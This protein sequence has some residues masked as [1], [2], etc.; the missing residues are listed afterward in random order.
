MTVRAQRWHVP[1]SGRD[2]EEEH[3]A[4]TP[5][6]LFFDLCFVVAVAQASVALHHEVAEGHL[7]EG[8]LFFGMTFF[9]IWWAWMNFTWFAS[10]YDTDDVLYRLLTFVQIAGVLVIAS[11]VERAFA[12]LDYATM[13]VGYLIMRIG[14]VAQWLRVA[15]EHP[16][17]RQTALR[18]AIGVSL[19]QV[20]WVSRLFLPAELGM[21][22]FAPLV[23]LELLVPVWA[24]STGH[25]TPFH[26]GHIAERYGLFTIIVLGECILAA[27]T[28]VQVAIS[29]GGLSAPL[30]TLAAGG[31]L[32]V[33]SMW[34]AYFKHDN[35]AEPAELR[36]AFIWGY[37]HYF[38][39]AAVAATG[40]GLHVAADLTH[41][42]AA[43]GP[44]TAS[45]AVAVPVVIYLVTTWLVSSSGRSAAEIT[46]VLV[47]CAAVLAVAVVIGMGSVPIAVLGM[48]LAVAALVGRSAYRA[49]R[50]AAQKA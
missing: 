19:V 42:E 7:L 50:L 33:L 3:R 31:L 14:L 37:G 16:D 6:E 12:E 36:R 26:R 43:I 40:A 47:G 28:A 1:M 9:A 4:A 17:R 5:L 15:I 45:L 8:A 13:T 23:V 29:A 11:G 25:P 27:S 24:E 30:L 20:G 38:V 49:S 34:W 35:A 18:F 44:V 10:A 2:P 48:G 32:L 41:E 21:A 39:F 22:A 46:P